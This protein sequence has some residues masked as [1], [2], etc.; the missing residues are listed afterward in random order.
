M[1]LIVLPSSRRPD[2]IWLISNNKKIIIFVGLCSFLPFRI[3][4]NNHHLYIMSY[5]D[6][7]KEICYPDVRSNAKYASL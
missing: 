5:L 7:I 6:V 2:F 3:K 4:L 1:A